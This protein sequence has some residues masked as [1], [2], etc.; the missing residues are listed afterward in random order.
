[1]TMLPERDTAKVAELVRRMHARTKDGQLRWER[2]TGN[3]YRWTG[4]KA[5]VKLTEHRLGIHKL[6]HG[7]TV[8]DEQDFPGVD[9]LWALVHETHEREVLRVIDAITQDLDQLVLERR[10]PANP[11]KNQKGDLPPPRDPR[12]TQPETV[13]LGQVLKWMVII[14]AIVV[15]VYFA[16]KTGLFA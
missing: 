13:W 5:I 8:V 14:F 12:K 10:P 9:H 7:E 4:D 11:I 1:M 15:A 3:V 6:P 16:A 2:G